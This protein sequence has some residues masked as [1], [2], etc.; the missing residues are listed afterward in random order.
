MYYG[1][2]GKIGIIMPATGVAPEQEFHKYQPEGVATF[3]QRILF[4][5][6]TP[7]GLIALADRA[8]EASKTLATAGL[9]IIVFACTTGSLIKG[10]GYDKELTKRIEDASGCKTITTSTAVLEA[11]KA[12]SA[13]RVLVTT[14]YSDEVNDIEKKFLE[15]NGFEVLSIR[16][17]GY[18]D[19]TLMPKVT[20]DMMHRLNREIL[21]PEADTL[22]VSCTG[23]GIMDAIPLLE[24]DSQ[25]PI[26]SSNQASL[27]AALRSISI[28]D[29]LPIGKLLSL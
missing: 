1:W 5:R 8:V 26:V 13:K 27:W 15:D 22:F 11:L 20:P 6:V 7:D 14:P 9:D 3:T 4:E 2:R 23:I 12:L 19:P 16:G 17:L 29:E 25:L 21:T 24:S 18:V 28:H 10:Y